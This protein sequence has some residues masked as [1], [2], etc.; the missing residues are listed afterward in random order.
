VKGRDQ[1]P[2]GVPISSATLAL[3]ALPE[4]THAD[5]TRCGHVTPPHYIDRP[6]LVLGHAAGPLLVLGLPRR[7]RARLAA[8]RVIDRVGCWLCGHRGGWR[9]AK[10]LWIVTGGWS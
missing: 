6:P 1:C 5:G 7:T 9:L 10:A 2:A 8:Q 4:Y 3:N